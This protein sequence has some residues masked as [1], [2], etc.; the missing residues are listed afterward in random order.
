M[1]PKFLSPLEVRLIG[2]QS[3]ELLTPLTFEN[4]KFV[5][6]VYPGFDYDG[7]S[8][9][10]A[11]WHIVGCPM[12]G[13]YSAAACI[14]DALYASRLFNRKTCDKLF[15][16][17]MIASGTDRSL[18]KRMYLA[19]RAFGESSYE[20]GEDLSKYRNLVKIDLK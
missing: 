18:A 7:A 13:L 12:G 15:H 8:I 17:A 11:L 16:E 9:P 19:V 1:K 14:H 4:A 5:I 10:Q 20:E 3:F 6:T 2:Y